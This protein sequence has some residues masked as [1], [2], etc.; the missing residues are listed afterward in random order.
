MHCAPPLLD[1]EIGIHSGAVKH[2]LIKIKKI[3]TAFKFLK[4]SFHI[5]YRAN[6]LS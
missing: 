5:K 3:L 1:I 4:I 6:S 2:V